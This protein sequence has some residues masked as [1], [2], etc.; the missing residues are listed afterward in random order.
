MDGAKESDLFNFKIFFMNK[1]FDFIFEVVGWVKIVLSPLLVGAIVGFIVYK[2]LGTPLGLI[3]GIG[4]LVVGLVIG[5]VWATNVWK[6]G[7]TI[8]FLSRIIATPELD[9]MDT[10]QASICVQARVKRFSSEESGIGAPWKSGVRPNHFFGTRAEME[11]SRNFN[12]GE[13]LFGE[14]LFFPEETKIVEVKFLWASNIS[15]IEKG[16]KLLICNGPRVVG[17]AEVLE[18]LS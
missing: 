9:N 13:I 2:S 3:L 12:I 11:K 16:T 15:K 10:T 8:H 5:M 18:R 6:K 14:E 17:E 1:I 4:I 7:G